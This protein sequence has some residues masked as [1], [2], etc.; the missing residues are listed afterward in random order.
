MNSERDDIGETFKKIS[1]WGTAVEEGRP[2]EAELE[3]LRDLQAEN[4]S[5]LTE[6][7]MLAEQYQT[8]VAL[9]TAPPDLPEDAP[10]HPLS[11]IARI[12]KLKDILGITGAPPILPDEQPRREESYG[13]A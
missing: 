9:P 1:A 13:I 8:M 7:I 10:S 2:S 5:L 11:R 12:H 3:V 4:S 6:S